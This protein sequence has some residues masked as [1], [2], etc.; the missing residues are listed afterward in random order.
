[1]N[2]F[3]SHILRNTF[4]YILEVGR[5]KGLGLPK[6]P[7]PQAHIRIRVKSMFWAAKTIQNICGEI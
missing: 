6:D 7:N 3:L 2:Q 5:N 4:H 1:M